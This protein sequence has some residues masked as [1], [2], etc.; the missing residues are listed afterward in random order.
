MLGHRRLLSRVARAS[1]LNSFDGVLEQMSRHPGDN[2]YQSTQAS[3]AFYKEENEVIDDK[4]PLLADPSLEMKP[5]VSQRFS[6]PF[7]D[8]FDTKDVV[9]EELITHDVSTRILDAL[10]RQDIWTNRERPDRGP[11]STEILTPAQR[12]YIENRDL[13]IKRAVAYTIDQAQSDFERATAEIEDEWKFYR[14]PVVRPDK[15]LLWSASGASNDSESSGGV[16]FEKGTFPSIEQLC[17]FLNHEEIENVVSVDLESCG[18]RDIGEWALIGT[19]QSAAH[20]G[21]VGS[22]IRKKINEL[23]LFQIKC[24][25]NTG[26]PGQEWVVTRL[27]PVVLHLMTSADRQN[28]KLEDIYTKQVLID[29]QNETPALAKESQMLGVCAEDQP[30]RL[31]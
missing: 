29:H 11:V 19:A 10:D 3:N 7:G 21:R 28:Y 14:D 16:E 6:E 26:I 22:L 13:L 9:D 8:V 31:V 25:I 18:R 30:E 15:S 5:S 12:F 2:N 24:F 4:D 27:G 1:Y 17:D 20:A 23:D